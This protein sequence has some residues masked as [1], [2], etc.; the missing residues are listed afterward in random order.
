MASLGPD[1]R[2]VVVGQSPFPYDAATT[3]YLGGSPEPHLI[4]SDPQAGLSLPDAQNRGLAFLF[5]P[6]SE[7]HRDLVR[8]LYLGGRDGEVRSQGGKLLFYTYVVP[9]V[10]R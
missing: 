9:F 3:F 10:R 2:A 1:Y 5:F 4:V 6:G 8:Q 7:Q